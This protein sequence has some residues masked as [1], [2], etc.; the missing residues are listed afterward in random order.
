VHVEKERRIEAR[1]VFREEPRLVNNVMLALPGP[2]M[3][4]MDLSARRDV[5]GYVLQPDAM[6]QAIALTSCR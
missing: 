6:A 4:S 2:L 5:E 1:V 3:D